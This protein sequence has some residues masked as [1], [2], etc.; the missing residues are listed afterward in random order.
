MRTLVILTIVAALGCAE[1]PKTINE[2]LMPEGFHTLAI[3]AYRDEVAKKVPLV[4]MPKFLTA[5]D[6]LERADKVYDEKLSDSTYQSVKIG[7][8]Y[9][10]ISRVEFKF[11]DDKCGGAEF[12]KMVEEL[13]EKLGCKAKVHE[14]HAILFLRTVPKDTQMAEFTDCLPEPDYNRQDRIERYELW[15]SEQGECSMTLVISVLYVEWKKS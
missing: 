6:W 10:R 8:K 5:K 4:S 13:N 7:F 12:N 1:K 14:P 15:W 9:D 3:G 11:R 2:K